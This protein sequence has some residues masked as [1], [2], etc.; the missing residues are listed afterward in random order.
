MLPG[1]FAWSVHLNRLGVPLAKSSLSLK[2]VEAFEVHL[3]SEGRDMP[4][5]TIETR[6]QDASD[7]RIWKVQGYG[8]WTGKRR[9][10]NA[11]RQAC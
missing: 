5:C 2:R 10:K 1:P 9:G 4:C 8:E 11:V 7:L 6:C 3:Q